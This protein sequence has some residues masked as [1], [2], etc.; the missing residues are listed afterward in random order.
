[1]ML[2]HASHLFLTDQPEPARDAILA[3]LDPK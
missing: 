3:F 2:P 1:V